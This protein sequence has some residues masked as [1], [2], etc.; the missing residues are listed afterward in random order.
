M[1]HSLNLLDISSTF[2][3]AVIYTTT[4]NIV[5]LFTKE[6][7]ATQ[8]YPVCTGIFYKQNCLQVFW[9]FSIPVELLTA[10]ASL[11]KSHCTS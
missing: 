5:L 1:L 8:E 9:Y 6:S 4:I 2:A 10:D 11:A 7:Q 3:T